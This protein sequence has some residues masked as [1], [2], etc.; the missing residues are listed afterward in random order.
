MEGTPGEA[1]LTNGEVKN[2][3]AQAKV[4]REQVR[5][6]KKE[7]LQGMIALTSLTNEHKQLSISQRTATEGAAQESRE[8]WLPR[9]AL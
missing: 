8:P 5:A 3:V 1:V 2:T 9:Q 4:S 7:T 6:K